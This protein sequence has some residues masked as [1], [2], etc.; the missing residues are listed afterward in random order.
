MF[1]HRLERRA[2]ALDGARNQ[3]P[4]S[5]TT[6]LVVVPAI[7]HARIAVTTTR[8]RARRQGRTK[9]KQKHARTRGARFARIAS[10]RIVERALLHLKQTL[11]I[12][13]FA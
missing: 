6:S 10:H 5:T 12:E 9:Q 11:K 2:R 3:P 4:S 7:A 1:L 13:L 8:T